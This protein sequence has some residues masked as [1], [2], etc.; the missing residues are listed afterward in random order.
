MPVVGGLHAHVQR[1]EVLDD[2]L[3]PPLRSRVSISS[4]SRLRI[5]M[6]SFINLSLP[7]PG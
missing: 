6:F 2:V 5:D 3:H 4:T 1:R 7:A